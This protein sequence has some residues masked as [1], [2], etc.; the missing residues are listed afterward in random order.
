MN[1][2][3]LKLTLT[4]IS[5]AGY[6]GTKKVTNT[7]NWKVC[8]I[9]EKNID[10]LIAEETQKI[11]AQIKNSCTDNEIDSKVKTTVENHYYDTYLSSNVRTIGDSTPVRRTLKKI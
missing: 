3:R 1:Y 9:E 8:C 4:T 2:K 7:F 5:F 10:E 11:L 6:K